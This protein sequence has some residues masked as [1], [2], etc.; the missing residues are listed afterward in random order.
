[1][2]IR[3]FTQQEPFTP[4]VDHLLTDYAKNH[5]LRALPDLFFKLAK[6]GRHGS[7][8]CVRSDY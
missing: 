1:M 4:D 2:L 5:Y 3:M 8:T 7:D 6:S